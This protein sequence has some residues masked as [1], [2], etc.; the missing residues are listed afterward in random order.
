MWLFLMLEQRFIERILTTSHLHLPI[1]DPES[2]ETCFSIQFTHCIP[3][4]SPLSSLTL[5]HPPPPGLKRFCG[6]HISS[7]YIINSGEIHFV[8]K[9]IQW[10]KIICLITGGYYSLFFL[11]LFSFFVSLLNWKGCTVQSFLKDYSH[12]VELESSY[13][14]SR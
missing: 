8:G 9:M 4:L 6:T 2:V 13:Y 7:R 11:C 10:A 1:L 14:C 3:I 5:Y 12:P